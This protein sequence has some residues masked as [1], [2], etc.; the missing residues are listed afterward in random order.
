MRTLSE[1][2]A[3]IS[4][5]ALVNPLSVVAIQAQEVL[6]I[7]DASKEAVAKLPDDAN[8]KTVWAVFSNQRGH[9]PEEVLGIQS[10]HLLSLTSLIHGAATG[11]TKAAADNNSGGLLTGTIPAVIDPP[12]ATAAADKK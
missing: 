2:H 7:V 6:E 11:P 4:A 12:K 3:L 10:G 5:K 1:L 9:A 8:A